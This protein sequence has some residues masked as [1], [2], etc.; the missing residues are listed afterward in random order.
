MIRDFSK[1]KKEELYRNLDVIDNKEWKPFMI[2][3][4]GRAGEFGVW[5]D[6]LGISAYTR[7]IDNYQN[8]I[9]DTNDSTRNQ[10]DVIFENVAETDHRYAEILREYAETVKEQIARIQVMAGIMG[11]VNGESTSKSKNDIYSN[12]GV[13]LAKAVDKWIRN[14]DD[15]LKN[16]SQCDKETQTAIKLLDAQ[17]CNKLGITDIN[18]RTKIIQTI[19]DKNPGTFK[20][21]YILNVYSG[22]D[23][24]RLMHITLLDIEQ[25]YRFLTEEGL[26]FLY[27]LE[28]GG[29]EGWEQNEILEL[30]EEGNII[31]IKVHD[32]GDGG[33]TI[34]A[35]IFISKDD[36]DRIDLAESLNIDWD[37]CEE[38]VSI[39]NVNTMFSYVTPYYHG[40]VK[41]VEKST[42]KILTSEQYDAVFSLLY[43]RPAL[44]DNIINLINSNADK[45]TWKNNL[46]GELQKLPEFPDNP[47]WVNRI[48]RTVDLYF[49]GIYY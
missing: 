27:D 45:E 48:E 39:E 5:A 16:F 9:L 11:I 24:Q 34:G 17:I 22:A 35:G 2:W 49:D 28:L 10:I 25:K 36:Q 18:E 20:N 26:L 40:L 30:D 23:Y 15:I 19:L 43:L 6:K 46:L 37:N 4:G 3:C 33:Y 32:A 41:E 31:A 47:G 38:W 12:E 13:S 42:D 1:G 7:Q 8:R 21:L 29:R 14:S 44:Q